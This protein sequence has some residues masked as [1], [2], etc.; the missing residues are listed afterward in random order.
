MSVHQPAQQSA[1][2]TPRVEATD[3]RRLAWTTFQSDYSSLIK[4]HAGEWVAYRGSERLGFARTK[5][6]LYQECLHR[7][8][9]REEF[10]VCCIEPDVDELYFGPSTMD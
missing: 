10:L 6:E 4:D 2:R 3:A 8:L 7:G 5:T 1:E 9:N